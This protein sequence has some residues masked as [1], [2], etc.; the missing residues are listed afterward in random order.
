MARSRH[1]RTPW[2]CLIG[3]VVGNRQTIAVERPSPEQEHITAL[4]K[5]ISSLTQTDLILFPDGRVWN[6]RSVRGKNMEVVG[7]VGSNSRTEDIDSLVRFAQ[8]QVSDLA[9]LWRIANPRQRERVQTLLFEGGLEYHPARG[10]SNPSKSSLFSTLRMIDFHKT[11]LVE[12]AG[13]G[14][15]HRA[16]SK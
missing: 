8:L 6:V 7:W 9:H 12:A 13:V 1:H 3:Q 10:F 4:V 2:S 15:S 14:L 11:S 5:Q 16:D